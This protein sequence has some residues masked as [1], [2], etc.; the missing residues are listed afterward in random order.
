MDIASEIAVNAL[1]LD[2]AFREYE[3]FHAYLGPAALKRRAKAIKPHD[4]ALRLNEIL[5]NGETEALPDVFPFFRRTYAEAFLDCLCAQHDIFVK[6]R[7]L[8]FAIATHRISACELPGAFNLEKELA[9]LKKT[10]GTSGFK[11]IAQFRK[12]APRIKFSSSS[13]LADY[14][15]EKAD[16]LS[17]FTQ[18]R[19]G[20]HI[21]GL[22]ALLKRSTLII[23]PPKPGE[24]PCYYRYLGNYKGALGLSAKSDFARHYVHAF[25]MHEVMP[26]HHLYSLIRQHLADTQPQDALFQ[27][28]TFYSPENIINEG[29][30]V[31]GDLIL[32]EFCPQET[33]LSSQIEK[34]LHKVLYNA[35]HGRNLG[36][37]QIPKNCKKLLCGEAGFTAA[38]TQEKLSFYAKQ[39]KYYT[40]VY[41]A[42]TRLVSDFIQKHGLGALAFVYGQ[43]CHA[44]LKKIS[45]ELHGKQ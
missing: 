36:A 18:K 41:P 4:A 45:R 42:G 38:E 30:A 44:A 3:L 35:W 21:P 11:T 12:N 32:G 2:P 19:L 23:E 16:A 34:F 37:G 33:L 25:I 8:P 31:N 5:Q 40:P 7:R 27:L 20:R 17:A 13:E 22:A 43:P 10:L 39:E 28:D 29:L 1:A 24:P 14:A 26:G 15:L 9:A 6:K